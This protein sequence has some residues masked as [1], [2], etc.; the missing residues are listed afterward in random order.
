MEQPTVKGFE[1]RIGNPSLFCG[2]KRE[3]KLFTDWANGIPEKRSKSRAILA[4]RK[5]GKT[6]IMQRLFNNLWRQ[7]GPVIPFYI[8]VHDSD[9]WALDF[10]DRYFRTFL[11]Q[12]LSFKTG[13]PLSFEARP[14]SLSVLERMGKEAGDEFVLSN[15]QDFSEY[16]QTEQVQN[17]L[18][19]AF[20]APHSFAI[21]TNA[22][23]LVMIDEIQYMTKYIYWDKERK[24]QAYNLPGMFHGLS[25]SK[26]APMLVSGSYIGWMVQMMTEMFVGGRLKR[27][28]LK[29]Q[30]E[31]KDGLEAIYRY[32]DYYRVPISDKS[33]HV[34]N[35]LT[36]SDPFYIATIIKSDWEFRDFSSSENTIKTIEHEILNEDGDIFGT[37]SEY[38]LNTVHQVNDKY[39]KKILLF[40][41][42]E[43]YQEH[44]R[45]EISAHLDDQVPERKLEEKLR[46]L[47]YGDLITR[48]S[49]AF[50]Y[51][52]IKDDIL[53]M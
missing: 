5:S 16:L 33:A 35:T 14:W 47:L 32:A 29:S 21:E 17:A 15:I 6:A 39:A 37:W 4:R 34:L 52:G 3:M 28:K 45:T 27:T 31:E 42:K 43:R 30:L 11:S 51:R 20:T 36:Q 12:Y 46:T 53:D 50:H 23:F 40:L 9:V 38:I 7:K 24:I 19:T 48:G 2:R 41:S 1:E 8:E 10:A 18:D 25:E 44:T 49:S 26:V 13:K 22:S